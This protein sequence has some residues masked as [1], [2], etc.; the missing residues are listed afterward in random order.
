MD[1]SLTSKLRDEFALILMLRMRSYICQ[2]K[3][4]S[5]S[6]VRFLKKDQYENFMWIIRI[7][8]SYLKR[9]SIK[10]RRLVYLNK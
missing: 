2:T 9:F 3:K 10:E 5:L 4:F 8:N 1:A 7:I 6:F